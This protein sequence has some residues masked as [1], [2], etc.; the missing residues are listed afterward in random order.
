MTIYYKSRTFWG[1]GIAFAGVVLSQMYG[2]TLSPAEAA[3]F[4]TTVG[5]CLRIVTQEPI[6]WSQ[7]D[8]VADAQ[9][10]K[11]VQIVQDVANVMKDGQAQPVTDPTPK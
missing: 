8:P 7:P 3:G 4:L 11:D 9:I 1:L 2:I 5:V 10:A 6:D